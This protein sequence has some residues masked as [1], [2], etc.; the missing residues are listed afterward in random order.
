M[1][2]HLGQH[3]GRNEL[4]VLRGSVESFGRQLELRGMVMA[5]RLQYIFLFH[6]RIL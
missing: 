4:R 2:G 6:K 5:H 3:R 1:T